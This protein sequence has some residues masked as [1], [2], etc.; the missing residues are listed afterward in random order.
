MRQV[1]PGPSRVAAQQRG[2]AQAWLS[3][4]AIAWRPGLRRQAGPLIPVMGQ[5]GLTQ[6][7]ESL[8]RFRVNF[9]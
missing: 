5:S 1:Q 3:L 8:S 4:Q 9:G 7:A 2:S 6:S